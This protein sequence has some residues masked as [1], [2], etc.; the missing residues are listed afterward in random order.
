LKSR[1]QWIGP[2]IIWL[3]SIFIACMMSRINNQ[4]AGKYNDQLE[5]LTWAWPIII[6]AMI[7]LTLVYFKG[8]APFIGMRIFL[9]SVILGHLFFNTWAQAI[10]PQGSGAG[11]IYLLGM[12]ET[13]LL[14]IGYCIVLFI[15]K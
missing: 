7:Y 10:V 9:S 12:G 15:R 2:E 3:M 13:I 14:A 1:F 6:F 4:S 8:N 5:T 11:M